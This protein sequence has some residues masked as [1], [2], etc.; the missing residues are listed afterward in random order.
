MATFTLRH[1]GVRG[2]I[3][4]LHQGDSEPEALAAYDRELAKLE[5]GTLTLWRGNTVLKR[6][7]AVPLDKKKRRPRRGGWS[8]LGPTRD[9]LKHSRNTSAKRIRFGH[10]ELPKRRP[11]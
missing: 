2:G 10:E 11:E 3:K 4:L 1:V 5:Q 8:G 7:E 6:C 9:E